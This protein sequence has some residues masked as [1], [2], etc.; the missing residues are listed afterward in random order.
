MAILK[1]GI[2]GGGSGSV[3]SVVMTSWK[4][5]NVL[6]AKPVSVANPNTEGQAAQRTSFKS[7]AML[8]S[9][10]LTTYV[11]KV[12][13][14][15]SGNITGYNR[16]CS[17]NKQAFSSIGAFVPANFKVGG[18]Q[19][20]TVSTIGTCTHNVSGTIAV[21]YTN[22]S[23]LPATRSTD[24]AV[25]VVVVDSTGDVFV[26]DGSESRSNEE[27]TCSRLSAGSDLT[28]ELQCHVYPCFVSADGRSVSITSGGTAKTI[29]FGS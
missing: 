8:G 26:S 28:G 3:A 5:R 25:F 10:M 24:K 9:T 18:G 11:Q 23:G 21:E 29:N 2:L 12:E 16:F 6:K 13:N 17:Q 1:Q 22:A 14:V 27:A 7:I 4:G 15:I 20:P 19:L